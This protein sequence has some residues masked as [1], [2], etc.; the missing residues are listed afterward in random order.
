MQRV[1]LHKGTPKTATR[2]ITLFEPHMQRKLH[3]TAYLQGL[4]KTQSPRHL[5]TGFLF[6]KIISYSFPHYR[7]KTRKNSGKKSLQKNNLECWQNCLWFS[8]VFHCSFFG[9]SLVFLWFSIIFMGCS[10][11]VIVV[12]LGF[13]WFCCRFSVVFMF[14]FVGFHLCFNDSFGFP[15]VFFIVRSYFFNFLGFQ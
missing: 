14:F 10:L 8:I 12:F 4:V 1:F 3:F 6:F 15:L 2:K 11:L 13:L 7:R 5:K 9:F